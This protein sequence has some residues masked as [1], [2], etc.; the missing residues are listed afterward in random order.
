MLAAAVRCEARVIV[1]F[2]VKDFGPDSVKPYGLDVFTPDEFL[3]NQLHF[4]VEAI[5][6]KLAAQATARGIAD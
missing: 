5:A 4:G 3:I 6:E 2:N 1:T